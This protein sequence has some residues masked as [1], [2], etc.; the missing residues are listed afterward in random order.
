MFLSALPVGVARLGSTQLGS[1]AFGSPTS[2]FSPAATPAQ[3]IFGLSIFV[4]AITGGIFLVVTGLLIYV[5]ARFRHKA[6]DESGDPAQ[7]YGSNQI[8]TSWTV[9]PLLI[10]VMLFLTAARVIQAT[11]RAAKPK[12]ALD[13]E[14]VGHQFW[15]EYRYPK[16][17]VVTANELHIPVSNPQA[18][19]PTYLTMSSADVIH[20]FWVPRLA[21]KTDLVPNKVNT[22][23]VDPSTPG[24]YLG[25][26]AQYCGAQHAKMLLRVYADSPEEFAAWVKQQQAGAVE[27]TDPAVA[28]GKAVFERSACANCH[29]IR[30]AG[31]S[32]DG[33]PKFGPDLTHVGSRDTLASGAI[34]NTPENLR[35]WINDPNTMKPGA[36]MPAMR[37][38][39]SDLDA[40]TKYLA[41]LK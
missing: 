7:I 11:E 29:A 35:K 26:C 18:P 38:S 41:A 1:G 21:G 5:S 33:K 15:W 3:S 2:I 4:L 8:E 34:P 20:S 22:M 36:L 37:L 10:V 23:W 30:E 12:S 6:G 28:E 17:G 13:V 27:P 9:I 40:V 39:D 32:A 24:L 19:L 31:E 14:V 16:L 25:Q